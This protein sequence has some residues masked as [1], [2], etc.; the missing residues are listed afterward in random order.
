MGAKKIAKKLHNALSKTVEKYDI[1]LVKTKCLSYDL[2]YYIKPNVWFGFTYH[3][4]H[5]DNFIDLRFG[6]L[7]TFKDVIPRLVVIGEYFN[8]VKDLKF[9]P[10]LNDGDSNIKIVIEII[11]LTFESVVMQDNFY[12]DIK[13]KERLSL[14]LSEKIIDIEQLEKIEENPQCLNYKVWK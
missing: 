3:N 14:Y 6:E 12:V 11:K 2:L 8:Q 5:R 10:D 13:E 7:Y 9:I 1:K 4:D